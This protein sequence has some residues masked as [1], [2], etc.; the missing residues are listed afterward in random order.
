VWPPLVTSLWY[1]ALIQL[2]Q[3]PALCLPWHVTHHDAFKHKP[4]QRIA[5]A[6]LNMQLKAVR[7]VCR[8]TR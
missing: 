5:T 2:L 7:V 6:L 1:P 4:A 8:R 3:Q